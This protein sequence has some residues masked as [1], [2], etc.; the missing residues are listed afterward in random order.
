MDIPNSDPT[1]K[2]WSALTAKAR[3][4]S[5]P[6][7][8]DVRAAVRGAIEAEGVAPLRPAPTVWEELLALA[9]LPSLRGLFAGGAALAAA[10]LFVGLHAAV[11]LHDALQIAGPLV[12]GF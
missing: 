2:S 1:P 7:E 3:R 8:I 9:R 10:L 12:A 11:E 5:A 6:P 4:A